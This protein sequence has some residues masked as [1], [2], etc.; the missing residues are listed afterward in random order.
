M[1]QLRNKV[2]HYNHIKYRGQGYDFDGNEIKEVPDDV[3]KA[4]NREEFEIVNAPPAEPEP[5][6]IDKKLTRKVP[7]TIKKASRRVRRRK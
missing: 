7:K 5:E 1:A 6:T 4:A 2:N 3:A